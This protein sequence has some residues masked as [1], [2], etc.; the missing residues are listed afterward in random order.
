MTELFSTRNA[1]YV[2]NQ[3]F[4]LIIII[5]IIIIIEHF[6]KVLLSQLPWSS[7]SIQWGR[8]GGY[9]IQ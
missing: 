5:I 2:V 9:K 8:G 1:Y 7:L 6:S 4:Y 3:N